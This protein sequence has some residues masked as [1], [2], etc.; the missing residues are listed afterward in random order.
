VS[1]PSAGAAREGAAYGLE[2]SIGRLLIGGLWVAMGLVLVGVILMLATG[3]DPLDHGAIPPFDLAEIPS[4][5][6][7]LQPAGFLW[8]GIVLVI[9]LP[10]GRVVVAGVGFMAVHDRRMALISV[11]VLLVVLA[12]I[13]AAIG[14]GN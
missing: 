8:A 14:L 12:S 5:M 3:T 6:L 9:A 7:A 4:E 2:V 11:L 10:I 13:V 1:A